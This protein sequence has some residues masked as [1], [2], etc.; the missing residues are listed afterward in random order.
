MY[1]P[2]RIGPWQ[3]GNYNKPLIVDAKTDFDLVDLVSTTSYGMYSLNTVSGVDFA[4]EH[5]CFSN[6]SIFLSSQ[7]QTGFGVQLSGGE[8]E[9]HQYM[10]SVAASVTFHSDKDLLVDMVVGRL[11]AAPSA[12]ANIDVPNPIVLPLQVAMNGGG[13]NHYVCNTSFIS[14]QLDGG[15]APSTFFDIAAFWFFRN[16]D[17]SDAIMAQL[18]ANIAFHKYGEDLITFDPAR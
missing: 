1:R 6:T 15:S 3:L 11:A 4:G 8:E 9:M 12:T 16:I 10:Y 14:T 5:V 7:R 2:N 18:R 17:G 13:I